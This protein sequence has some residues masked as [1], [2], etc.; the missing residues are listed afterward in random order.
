MIIW[1]VNRL[2]LRQR[3]ILIL[4]AGTHSGQATIN[5]G[6]PSFIFQLRAAKELHSIGLIVLNGE[7]VWPDYLI[8]L[9]EGGKEWLRNLDEDALTTIG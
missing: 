2:T 3:D 6:A 8:S 9:T 7:S 5:P 1:D 4:L